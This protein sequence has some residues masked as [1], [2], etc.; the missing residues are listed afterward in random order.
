MTLGDYLPKNIGL[1]LSNRDPVEL[2]TKVA[3]RYRKEAKQLLQA[4]ATTGI[5]Q[6]GKPMQKLAVSLLIILERWMKFFGS[7]H[8]MVVNLIVAE[9]PRKFQDPETQTRRASCSSHVVPDN[10]AG[11][12]TS[13]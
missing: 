12:G 8:T 5:P 4:K 10:D 9:E 1:F 3:D 11:R 13:Q 2:Y 7:Y 6:I